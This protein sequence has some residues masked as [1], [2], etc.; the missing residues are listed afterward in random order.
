MPVIHD[1]F[2]FTHIQ[3]TA[4]TSLKL[5]F[6][7]SY[8]GQLSITYPH[9]IP[10]RDL[11]SDL[12]KDKFKFTIIR[13][14]FARQYSFYQNDSRAKREDGRFPYDSFEEYFYFRRNDLTFYQEYYTQD[15]NRFDKIYQTEKFDE[16]IKDLEKKFDLKFK[17]RFHYGSEHKFDRDYSEHYS[18]R[19]IKILREMEPTIFSKFNYRF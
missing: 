9:H 15:Y 18:K 14:P 17:Q 13:N 5:M 6:K 16:M 8:P 12:V 19:M 3:K 2:V 7:D 1:K 10:I 11:D 4:G